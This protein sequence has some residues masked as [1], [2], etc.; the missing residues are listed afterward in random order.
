MAGACGARLGVVGHGHSRFTARPAGLV[1]AW[2]LLLEEILE[3]EHRNPLT[4]IIAVRASTDLR[5]WVTAHD[6]KHL[7]ARPQ[8]QPRDQGHGRG[9][10]WHRRIQ[11][12]AHRPT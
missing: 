11:P 1:I 8:D 6:A 10:H 12:G 5:P 4:G 2:C 9:I 7:E 3:L